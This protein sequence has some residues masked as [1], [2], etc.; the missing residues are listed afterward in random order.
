MKKIILISISVFLVITLSF[1]FFSTKK[2]SANLGQMP[3]PEIA[4]MRVESKLT[5]IFDELP[6][7]TT[8]FKIT[9][10]RPQIGGII[11]KRL[12]TEGSDVKQ[13]QQLYQID[14]AVYQANYSSFKA[15]LQSAK[16]NLKSVE[17]RF[18]RYQELVK[19]EAISRQEFDDTSSQLEQARADVS[20]AQA[21]SDKAKIDLDYTKV[22]AP[23]SGKIGHSSVSEGALV[24]ANQPALLT[25]ITELNPIYID[26]TQ[27][28]ADLAKMRDKIADQER[29]AVELIVSGENKI[30][31]YEGNLQFA[32]S[33]VDPTTSSVQLRALFPN[34]DGTLLPGLFVRARIKFPQQN[35]ILIPQNAAIR[36]NEGAFSVWI[37]DEKNI[38]RQKKIEVA[39]AVGNQW[40]VTAGLAV[41]DIIVVEGFQ[42]IAP[43]V[44]ISPVFAVEKIE[45]AKA[46]TNIGNANQPQKQEE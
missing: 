7:R 35:L 3:M 28:S 45:P 10:I 33:V 20:V 17:A 16:A 40:I 21:N 37:M 39:Q 2:V 44:K 6:A 30:Y 43:D 26:I 4:V 8:A 19:V 13:G 18:K 24:V 23:I 22:Y 42:K 15:N 29:V 38:V 25:T 36:N 14:P 27:P 1:Y 31:E 41:G 12:F 46:A 32:E 34:P 5:A 11:T 9:E